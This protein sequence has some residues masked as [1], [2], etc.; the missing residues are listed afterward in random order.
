VRRAPLLGNLED[1]LQKAKDTGNSLHR[2]PFKSERN[3]GSGVG[4]FIP[5]TLNDE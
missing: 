4:G 2:G 1:M 5:G 3:L